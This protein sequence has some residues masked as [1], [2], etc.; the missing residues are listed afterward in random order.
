MLLATTTAFKMLR[1]EE[2]EVGLCSNNNPHGR[3]PSRSLL[4]LKV[5]GFLLLQLILLRRLCPGKK[6]LR[7]YLKK[8]F[9]RSRPRVQWPRAA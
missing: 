2:A 5:L 8:V 4:L 9:R 6:I 3:E 1:R 7:R